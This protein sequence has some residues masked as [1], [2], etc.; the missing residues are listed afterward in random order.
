MHT[1]TGRSTDA[2]PQFSLCILVQVAV[3]AKHK[4]VQ[5]GNRVYILLGCHVKGAQRIME[6]I[7]NDRRAP[8]AVDTTLV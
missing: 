1:H 2:N 5:F 4:R 3:L 8:Y 6:W 7:V